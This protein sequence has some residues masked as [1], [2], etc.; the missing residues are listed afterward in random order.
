MNLRQHIKILAPRVLPMT[1][2][3]NYAY[4]M[5]MTILSQG[6]SKPVVPDFTKAFDHICI[7]TGGKAVIDQV[8]R[9]LNLSD[10][11]TEPAKM[12]LNRFG[13]TSSSLVFYEL[14]YFEAKGRVKKVIKCG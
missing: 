11:V 10:E 6:K 5:I 14:A 1:Q 2:L 13:N 3:A 7:H 8:G 12:C 9:V 4:S